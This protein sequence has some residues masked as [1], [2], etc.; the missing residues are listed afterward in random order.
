MECKK[1]TWVFFKM[2][3]HSVVLAGCVLSGRLRRPYQRPVSG[4]RRHSSTALSGTWGQHGEVCQ[5]QGR[6]Q[7]QHEQVWSFTVSSLRHKHKHKHVNTHSGLYLNDHSL[8]SLWDSSN[9]HH[10][11]HWLIGGITGN[12]CTFFTETKAWHYVI[13]SLENLLHW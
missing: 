7:A 2:G 8:L 11:T 6:V 3:G 1:S 13:Y 4:L 10:I 12:K 9:L 5:V